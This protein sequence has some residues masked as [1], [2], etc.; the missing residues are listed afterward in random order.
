MCLIIFVWTPPHFWAL[1]IFRREDYAR[2]EIPMLPV[3]HGV[4]YTRW[5]ILLYTILLVLVSLLPSRY[6]IQRPDLLRRRGRA[7]CRFS[8]LRHPP[9][10]PSG[11]VFRHAGVQV[12]HRLLDGAVRV[13]AGRSLAGSA[14]AAA[15][16]RPAIGRLEKVYDRG[17]TLPH[18][19]TTMHA[20]AGALSAD[21]APVRTN[22]GIWTFTLVATST[23][24]RIGC[25]HC[26]TS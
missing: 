8:L 11:R 7:R 2:A 6:G 24:A 18:R 5:Q 17:L 22:Q 16:S 23:S 12:F 20:P 21:R 10:E 15:W 26:I 1:A 14:D 25:R 9:D 4:A 3:T 13:F 19:S